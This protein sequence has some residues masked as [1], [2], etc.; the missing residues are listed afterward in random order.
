MLL[1]KKEFVKKKYGAEGSI[2][3]VDIGLVLAKQ[4][5]NIPLVILKGLQ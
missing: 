5:T 4:S 3:N 2:S 1:V